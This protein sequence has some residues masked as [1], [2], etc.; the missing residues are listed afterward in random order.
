MRECSVSDLQRERARWRRWTHIAKPLEFCLLAISH[1]PTN[2]HRS[3]D[4]TLH[5]SLLPRAHCAFAASSAQSTSR[6]ARS[7]HHGRSARAGCVSNSQFTALLSLTARRNPDLHAVCTGQSAAG[8]SFSAFAWSRH[9]LATCTLASSTNRQA[10]ISTS[11][12]MRYTRGFVRQS[13][14][15]LPTSEQ[16]PRDHA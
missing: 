15:G 5:A 14:R 9:E 13:C 16:E 1:G 11:S 12:R 7:P 10:C 8:L 6:L 4:S 3:R 2:R